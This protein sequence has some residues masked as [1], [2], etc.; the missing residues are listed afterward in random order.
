MDD[1]NISF[2][3]PYAM[4]SNQQVN[5]VKN[6]ERHFLKILSPSSIPFKPI[7]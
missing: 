5:E 6:L 7:R 4:Q 3:I 2:H 1:N